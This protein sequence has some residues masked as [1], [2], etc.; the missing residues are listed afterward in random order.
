MM[1][2]MRC[3]DLASGSHSLAPSLALHGWG[4]AGRQRG[5]RLPIAQTWWRTFQQKNIKFCQEAMRACIVMRS[6]S[7]EI[8]AFLME[9][10]GV[11]Y[12]SCEVSCHVG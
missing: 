12:G 2:P 10:R 8:R 1:V 7:N 5:A 3:M 9:G 11:L 6:G 4:L